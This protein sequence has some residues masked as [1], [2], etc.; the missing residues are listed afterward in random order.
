M[1]EH[2][3][4]QFSQPVFLSVFVAAVSIV[5][6]VFVLL[7]SYLF[8]PSSRATSLAQTCPRIASVLVATVV[9][10][11]EC[12]QMRKRRR[13]M[14]GSVVC[15]V[16]W[17]V[18]RG[19]LTGG[20]TC[21]TDNSSIHTEKKAIRKKDKEIGKNK[22]T[23]KIIII[24][25]NKVIILPSWNVTVV[26]VGVVDVVA[27]TNDTTTQLITFCNLHRNTNNHCYCCSCQGC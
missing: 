15:H 27:R 19:K 9:Q 13:K 26:V 1:I 17:R 23:V 25:N 8:G 18:V 3:Q 24:D 11:E 22:I 21:S 5:R 12:E 10:R 14:G 20:S 7:S 6:F 16:M 2:A 4:Q